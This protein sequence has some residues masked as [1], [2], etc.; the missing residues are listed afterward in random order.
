KAVLIVNPSSGGE[1]SKEFEM[2]AEV[3][4][5]QIFD[6]VVE[7]QTEKGGDAEQFDCVAAERH[8]DSV[9]VMGVDETVNEAISGYAEQ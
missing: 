3:K 5:K 4:L 2:I 9:F 8:F 7:K 6:E 1:K